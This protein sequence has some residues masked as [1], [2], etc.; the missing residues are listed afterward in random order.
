MMNAAV[1]DRIRRSPTYGNLLS[2]MDTVFGS[3]G[4]SVAELWP[5]DTAEDFLMRVDIGQIRGAAYLSVCE[6]YMTGMYAAGPYG[7]VGIMVPDPDVPTYRPDGIHAGGLHDYCGSPEERKH[8][9][10][11]GEDLPG[12]IA[13]LELLKRYLNERPPANAELLERIKQSAT[14]KLLIAKMNL[15]FGSNWSVNELWPS[16]VA[17]DFRMK[18]DID[19]IRGAAYL[20]VRNTGL[21]QVL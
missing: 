15:A 2:A 5:D 19:G 10:L 11:S 16:G 20:S 3:D 21:S 9:F 18:V 4:W 7:H 14:Y 17:D 8:Y 12:I 6:T 1:L 13:Y